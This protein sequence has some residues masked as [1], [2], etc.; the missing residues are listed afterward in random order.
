MTA[1]HTS[2]SPRTA[3]DGALA[4]CLITG[5]GF[6]KIVGRRGF[7]RDGGHSL[8]IAMFTGGARVALYSVKDEHGDWHNVYTT[9]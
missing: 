2:A 1:T 5:N 6:G 7:E 4:S 9:H 3:L 8:P